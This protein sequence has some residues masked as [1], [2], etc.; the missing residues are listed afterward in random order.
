MLIHNVQEIL[1]LIVNIAVTCD[2]AYSLLNFVIP[3]LQ[4]MVQLENHQ[5]TSV[6]Y[7]HSLASV[8]WRHTLLCWMKQFS[9]Y[10]SNDT[11]M[12][13][14][15]MLMLLMIL[16][17]SIAVCNYVSVCRY[18]I[19]MVEGGCE[20]LRVA[21]FILYIYLDTCAC[22]LENLRHKK[23]V[24]VACSTILVE[25]FDLASIKASKYDVYIYIYYILLYYAWN[26]LWPQLQK[27]NSCCCEV[28]I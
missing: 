4:T 19:I 2:K 20:I 5:D 10:L 18:G 26:I 28:P 1:S 24:V 27:L 6:T 14:F 13:M 11:I 21:L 25:I 8:V 16:A 17:L 15:F 9:S 3:K 22:D 23:T 12:L 7:A